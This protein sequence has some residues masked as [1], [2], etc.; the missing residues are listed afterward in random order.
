MTSSALFGIAVRGVFWQHMRSIGFVMFVLLVVAVSI[1]L[2]ENL[3]SLGDK[4][5]ETDK[6][7]AHILLPYLGYRTVDIVT[8]LLPMA[9]LAGAFFAELMRRQRLEDV[10][11]AAA[12]TSPA[13]TLWALVL[14]G[15]LTGGIQA[16]LEAKI[17]PEAVFQ[18]VDLGVGKYARWWHPRET[19]YRWFI[20][21]D[22]ALR[23]RVLVG[24]S[25]E[26]RD[27]TLFVG[28]IQPNLETLITSPRVS[29]G[30]TPGTWQFH[31]AEVWQ[32]GI[33]DTLSSTNEDS[34][35]LSFPLLAEDLEYLGVG[36]FN[37]PKK[38][39]NTLRTTAR[40]ERKADI[41]TAIMRRFTA[42]LL[43]GVFI[44]LGASLA[45]SGY[46]G[47]LFAPARLI[48]LAALGYVSVVSVKVFW[49][50]G[51]FATVSPLLA[52]ILPLVW[53]LVLTICLQV[54]RF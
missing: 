10:I 47:R 30:K 9:C 22:R 15:I 46:K 14:V 50:L 16:T 31:T 32:R 12:G 41:D 36:A 26:L 2:T 40:A 11:Y 51:E 20:D 24:P 44:L 18:Q 25:P 3:D 4:A 54:R 39:L 38:A 45:Q 43:P 35:M 33:D 28:I 5:R 42:F 13:L 17:R 21:G 53:A 6:P 23:A 49:T 34:F 7:L 19:G 1:D 52:C 27:A 37:L 29:P 8:R 48:A